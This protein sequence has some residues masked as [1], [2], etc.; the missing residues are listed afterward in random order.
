M[1]G[2]RVITIEFL[3]PD[4]QARVP[5]CAEAIAAAHYHGYR[6]CPS[7]APDY[8]PNLEDV[9]EG[10]SHL[11][12]I[13]DAR[14]SQLSRVVRTHWLSTARILFRQGAPV[15]LREFFRQWSEDAPLVRQ[16][17]LDPAFQKV[18]QQAIAHFTKADRRAIRAEHHGRQTTG[19]IGGNAETL[20]A[21]A[22]LSELSHV[23]D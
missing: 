20:A 11:R 17:R 3:E 10:V 5:Q 23:H 21:F 8:P 13:K 7:E 12:K 16:T 15:P 1:L 18:K 2:A 6:L 19:K 4:L 22:N 9:I 14:Q